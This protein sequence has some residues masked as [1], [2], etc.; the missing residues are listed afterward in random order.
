MLLFQCWLL[1]GLPVGR[2]TDSTAVLDRTLARRKTNKGFRDDKLR[3]RDVRDQTKGRGH[4]K[5]LS[6]TTACPDLTG[7]I[8]DRLAT[9]SLKHPPSSTSPRSYE[10]N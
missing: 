3:L 2:R 7:A 4:D 9:P 1:M 10:W 5:V 6:G 8:S